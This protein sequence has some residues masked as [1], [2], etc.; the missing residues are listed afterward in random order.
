MQASCAEDFGDQREFAEESEPRPPHLH[1][2]SCYDSSI[3]VM[4]PLKSLSAQDS[5]V[6]EGESSANTGEVEGRD[7]KHELDAA[8][9][10]PGGCA[11]VAVGG[12]APGNVV[13]P[14]ETQDDAKS[15]PDK[16]GEQDPRTQILL[17]CQK[18]CDDFGGPAQYLNGRIR[19]SEDQA[20]FE[21]LLRSV[22]PSSDLVDYWR[23]G[24]K[25]HSGQ[26]INVHPANLGRSASV[27]T[28]PL[29]YP[30]TFLALADEI[31]SHSFLTD[32][33]PLR[34]WVPSSHPGGSYIM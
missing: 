23:P 18:V 16:D 10:V 8:D 28:K 1:L 12:C 27:T 9:F 21:S 4:M 33:E 22:L 20:S 32:E 3:L 6:E 2:F 13:H 5:Y 17:A 25:I 30:K 7:C 14:L 19:T 11:P 29:P 24:V 15:E 31:L 34:V 26:I